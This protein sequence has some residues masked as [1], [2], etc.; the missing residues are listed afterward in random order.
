MYTFCRFFNIHKFT[1]PY[2]VFTFLFTLNNGIFTA[3]WFSGKLVYKH[4]LKRQSA[5][6]GLRRN[7][8]I[9]PLNSL[10]YKHMN[11]LAEAY[12]AYFFGQKPLCAMC[13]IFFEKKAFMCLFSQVNYIEPKP[14][15]AKLC[16]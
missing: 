11:F 15:L 4:T 14:F 1:L 6:S 12:C 10:F 3:C 8:I 13:L 9:C 2:I 16:L 7:P 5:L